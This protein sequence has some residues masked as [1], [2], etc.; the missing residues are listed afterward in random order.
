VPEI[1]I[2]SL[3]FIL[4]LQ[5]Q[6]SKKSGKIHAACSAFLLAAAAMFSIGIVWMNFPDRDY[7]PLFWDQ[8]ISMARDLDTILPADAT[9]CAFWPGAFAQFSNRRVRSLDGIIGS[10]EFFMNYVKTGKE[11]DYCLEQNNQVH[12]IIYLPGPWEDILKNN[13]PPIPTWSYVGMVRLW[14]KR[15]YE[16]KV[17][18]TRIIHNETQEG[19]YLIA[20]SKQK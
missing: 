8:R 20:I 6:W 16:M 18:K 14:E 13:P 11:I 7:V 4:F 12:I 3:I 1:L 2:V 9:V 10:E 19:W 5:N 15:K 17:L